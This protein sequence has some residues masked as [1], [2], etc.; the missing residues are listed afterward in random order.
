M[1]IKEKFKNIEKK[2]LIIIGIISFILLGII[3]INLPQGKSIINNLSE[4]KIIGN[5]LQVTGIGDDKIQSGSFT[6]QFE[7]RGVIQ[8]EVDPTFPCYVR[9]YDTIVC[10]AIN[11]TEKDKYCESDSLSLD[12]KSD[13]E[14]K[15][16]PIINVMG[17]S[18]DE[19]YI[20]LDNV[21]ETII[22]VD[23][24]NPGKFQIGFNSNE[25]EVIDLS[26]GVFNQ[27]IE[28]GEVY[29]ITTDPATLSGQY[30]SE[31]LDMNKT[32]SVANISFVKSEAGDISMALRTHNLT[33]GTGLESDVVG[34]W[35]MDGGNFLDFSGNNNT[36]TGNG[37][38][39]VNVSGKF[40]GS[41]QF[42]GSGDY[43]DLGT[44][45][46]FDGK[47]NMT[48]STW[49]KT[50]G[51]SQSII[52]QRDITAWNGVW[53]L[54]IDSGGKPHFQVRNVSGYQIESYPYTITV[55]D[56]N[57][58]HVVGVY[59]GIKIVIYIDGVAPS[60][61]KQIKEG[62]SVTGTIKTYIGGDI[63]SGTNYFNGQMDEVI[64]SNRSLNSTEVLQLYNQG[65]LKKWSDWSPEYTA[66]PSD[67]E[68]DDGRY[69]QVRGTLSRDVGGENVHLDEFTMGFTDTGVAPPVDNFPETT[70]ITTNQ[71][72]FTTS[73]VELNASATD[74]IMLVNQSYYHN[75]S[76]SFILNYTFSINGTSNSTNLTMPDI[77]DGK[78]LWNVLTCDNASQC[79]W[80]DSNRTFTVSTAC[81]DANCYP[82]LCNDETHDCYESCTSH[83][84]VN[85]SSYCASDGTA[86][87]SLADTLD[88]ANKEWSGLTDNEV[89]TSQTVGY[90]FYD[91]FGINEFCSSASDGCV[92]NEIEYSQGKYLCV[93]ND[94]YQCLGG[95]SAW[96][97]LF[98][99]RDLGDPYDASAKS[100]L[101]HTYCGYYYAETCNSDDGCVIPSPA[102][103]DCG[104]YF[105]DESNGGTCSSGTSGCDINCG[106][107]YDLE[108]CPSPNTL[109]A[110]CTTCSPPEEDNPPI[111]T[112][113]SPPDSST[114]TTEEITFQY[115]ITDEFELHNCSLWFNTTT[116]AWHMNQ[117]NSS[118]ISRIATNSFDAI[119][120]LNDDNVTWNV[121]C[122]D[123]ASHVD[124]GDTNFTF[125]IDTT[126]VDKIVHEWYFNNE[127]SNPGMTLT[128]PGDVN[129][130]RNLDVMGDLRVFGDVIPASPFRVI[131]LLVS[132][133][134]D[135]VTGGNTG[136]RF[137]TP[138]NEFLKITGKNSG[139]GFLIGVYE[140]I[141]H[142]S[143]TPGDEIIIDD[144]LKVEGSLNVTEN[145]TASNYCNSTDCY[146]VTDFLNDSSWN[147]INTINTTQMED[148][149]GVLNILVSWLT[150]LFYQKSE[151][152]NKTETYNRSEVYNTTEIDDKNYI[153]STNVA[154]YN[155]TNT[156]AE[157]QNFSKNI[158]MNGGSL[159][160][161]K[162]ATIT[163]SDSGTKMFIDELGNID[164]TLG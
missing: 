28:L 160:L 41:A 63:R 17:D 155:N 37:D 12:S 90:C 97:S 62:L 49:I 111:V 113:I 47:L 6:S 19:K 53:K 89:C 96:S 43:V 130:T 13:C 115:S 35:K 61:L 16:V 131:E 156:W 21:K 107:D 48:I 68:V 104:A 121:E 24:R 109:S 142:L 159:N 154:Y 138:Y 72:I 11:K 46:S 73:T 148:N 42:D 80:G 79:D 152:Y 163:R 123:N 44:G 78:Y 65:E 140:D 15:G 103:Q 31:I 10:G 66:S 23:L 129:I 105:Y 76:G 57:W 132:E 69:A 5:I 3:F 116:I 98:D 27:T 134:F 110:D 114:E 33:N 147:G 22:K 85:S 128:E 126:Y 82:Y 94:H 20:S 153:N 137:T 40:D 145:I 157:N 36:G 45:S 91:V 84:H 55:N 158:T 60:G 14:T 118:A 38:V 29:L 117:T 144:N 151:V 146:T 119:T 34:Y 93:G 9:G 26:V 143:S 25:F 50:T 106:A 95:E 75:I 64:I 164:L 67:V 125:D 32:M 4:N 102:T 88:C 124:W 135:L 7:R 133:Y 30:Y 1:K 77:P 56:G 112:L 136:V 139:A 58:H 149:N 8:K 122:Y 74:D 141:V 120:F 86:Q 81:V 59:N 101:G 162:N 52:E 100:S 92:N 54:Y 18:V 51:V 71:K 99:C 127:T 70:L 108:T 161:D 87:T 39:F 150:S 2:N 83:T